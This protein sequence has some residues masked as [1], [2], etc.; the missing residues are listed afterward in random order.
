[1]QA[2]AEDAGEAARRA[3][4]RHRA[5][6][7]DDALARL[8]WVA[9]RV[10]R[11]LQR[12]VDLVAADHGITAAEYH[13][14][15]AVSDDVGRSNAE[16]ARLTFVTPQSANHVLAEL[17]RNGFLQRTSD[18]NHGRIRQTK[19]TPHGRAVLDACV[20]RIA[21]IESRALSGLSPAQT[22]TLLPALRQVADALAG[23]YFGDPVEE[24]RAESVRRAR[25][26]P[27]QQDRSA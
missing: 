27:A 8:E 23:G 3:A 25:H 11:A 20:R 1:V 18:P 13:L 14:L 17:E 19:L 24:A 10:S 2:D 26:A 7:P 21:E 5:I 12:A 22:E 4:T 9:Q 16:I 6:A 15:L